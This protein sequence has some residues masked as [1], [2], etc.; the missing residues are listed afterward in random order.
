[1]KR[2]FYV[3]KEMCVNYFHPKFFH[4][5]SWLNALDGD[6]TAILKHKLVRHNFE[7][8]SFLDNNIYMRSKNKNIENVI[9]K[10]ESGHYVRI[11]S[12]NKRNKHAAEFINE[13]S[14]E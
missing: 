13:E 10:L 1:M 14:R 3:H 6:H 2:I 11:S 12:L 5:D 9:Y 7:I 4:K 8:W